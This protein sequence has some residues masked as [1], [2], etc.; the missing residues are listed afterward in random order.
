[1]EKSLCSNELNTLIY[2]S[3]VF[4]VTLLSLEQFSYIFRPPQNWHISVE[5]NVLRKMRAN[6][7]TMEFSNWVSIW[8]PGEN[9][10]GISESK[11]KIQFH[12]LN[13]VSQMVNFVEKMRDVY[14][15]IFL[16]NESLVKEAINSLLFGVWGNERK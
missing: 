1:M 5:E 10:M 8:S 11:P 14:A 7:I 12:V 9:N 13:S 6:H 15:S 16:R 2:W 4:Q 3:T